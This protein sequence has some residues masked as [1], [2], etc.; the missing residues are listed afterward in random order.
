MFDLCACNGQPV[1]PPRDL[2][3]FCGHNITACARRMFNLCGCNGQPFT[4][5]TNFEGGNLSNNKKTL[6]RGDNS[7]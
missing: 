6:V 4:S 3:W 7:A 5:P 1:T 2:N